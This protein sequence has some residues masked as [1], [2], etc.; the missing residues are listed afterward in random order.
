MYSL[1]IEITRSAAD[2]L[3]ESLPLQVQGLPIPPVLAFNRRSADAPL[4]PPPP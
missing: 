4:A 2:F 1:N 3:Y